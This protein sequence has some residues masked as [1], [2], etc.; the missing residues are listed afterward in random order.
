MVEQSDL[1]TINRLNDEYQSIDQM[2]FL[3]DHGGRIS[4]FQAESDDAE[5]TN[6]IANAGVRSDYIEYPPQM[7]TAI[8][9]ALQQ[10]QREIA[11]DLADM[12]VTGIVTEPAPARRR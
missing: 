2:I 8:K 1:G 3:L 12:G 4:F 6:G 7:V 11:R 10:R 5:A 9:T